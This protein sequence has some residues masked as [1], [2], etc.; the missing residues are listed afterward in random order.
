MRPLNL[1]SR[2]FRNERLGE[3]LFAVG[4]AA[5]LAL[6]AWHALVIRDLLPARTSGLHREVA[7]LDAELAALRK[8]VAGRRTETPPAPVLAQWALV[9]DLVDQRTFSWA[10]LF[11]SLEG[12]IP[13]DVRLTSISP[14]VRKGQV[15]LDVTANVRVQSAGWEFVRALQSEGEFYDVFPTS[16]SEREFR[17]KFRYRPDAPGE[18]VGPPPPAPATGASPEA[19]PNPSTIAGAPSPVPSGPGVAVGPPAPGAGGTSSAGPSRSEGPLPATGSTP[20]PLREGPRS[21]LRS[22]GAAGRRE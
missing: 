9:K 21:R 19:E 12:V 13:D 18:P 8:E 1:A 4:A 5:L 15:E 16:E 2:P 3:A 6:T 20:P 14:S 11:A 10:G 22:S 7:A 17:Y